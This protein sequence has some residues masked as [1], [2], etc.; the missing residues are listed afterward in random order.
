MTVEDFLKSKDWLIRP[1]IMTCP[2][3]FSETL[4]AKR[5]LKTHV[6]ALTGELPASSMSN[7]TSYKLISHLQSIKSMLMAI[8][9]EG[10]QQQQYIVTD[11]VYFL[12]QDDINNLRKKIT[13]TTHL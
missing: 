4:K 1:V 10:Y 3:Y 2:Q 9:C 13:N 7:V 5:L 12:N 11:E 6:I 8:S